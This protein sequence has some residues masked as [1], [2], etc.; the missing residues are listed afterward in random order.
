MKVA[1]AAIALMVIAGQA[2]A[3]SC[4]RPDA[5]NTFE[6][7]SEDAA[8]YYLLYG[9]LDFDVAKQPKGVVNAERN[10]DPIVAQF[11]GFAL[12]TSGFTTS[13]SRAV[14]LQPVCFGPWCGG[15]T[16]GV[17]SLF[18]AQVDGDQI[19]IESTPCGGFVLPEPS[20]SLLDKMTSCMNGNCP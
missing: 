4:V 1:F 17:K 5:V 19:I 12:N 18:F 8:S 6:R 10:P 14:T 2:V 7:V 13:Y 9:T 16:P 20:Q 11:A 15:E 3:L